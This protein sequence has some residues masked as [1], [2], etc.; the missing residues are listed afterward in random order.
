MRQ[1][2]FI[3]VILSM[4]LAAS[5]AWADLPAPGLT[6]TVGDKTFSNFTCS[7]GTF[8]EFA[9]PSDCSTISV[10][11]STDTSGNLGILFT[12][13]FGALYT[14]TYGSGSVDITIDYTVTALSAL[15]TDLHMLF[16]GAVTGNGFAHVTEQV[17]AGGVVVGTI[18]VGNPVP[19]EETGVVFASGPYTTL[20]V[21]KDIELLSGPASGDSATISSIGQ[22]F[23][24]TTV[25]EP[26]SILLFGTLLLGCGAL[27][28]K[29]A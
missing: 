5:G 24:Q 28:R 3:G 8:D 23:S 11:P 7:V 21:S 2:L 13:S 14:P 25:P 12:G 15:I 19:G 6:I 9:Y 17:N 26:A 16:N 18:A 22:Y 29:R 1:K 10:A 27:L 4:G 20:N